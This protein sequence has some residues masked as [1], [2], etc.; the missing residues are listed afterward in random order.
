MKLNVDLKRYIEANIFPQYQKNDK[1]HDLDHINYVIERSLK[2]AKTVADIDINMVYAS[3][4][5]H[6]I[7]HHIDAKNHEKVSADILLGDKGI[8]S[9]FT[10]EQ[11]KIMADAVY[12][13]RASLEYE[14]RT[15]YGKILSSADRNV[16]LMLPLIR[17]YEYRK[18]HNQGDELEKTIEESR[19]HILNKFGKKGYAK[20]KMYF[21][22]PEYDK[23]LNDIANLAEDKEAFRQE[24]IKVNHLENLVIK[25]MINEYAP[26]DEQEENDKKQMIRFINLFDDVLTRENT[27]GHFSSSAFVVNESCDKAL[28]LHHNVYNGYVCPGGHADGEHDLLEV[29]KR[30]VFEETSLNVVPLLNKNIF[31]IQ[32]L[33]IKGHV[34][35]G[36]HVSAHVHFDVIYMFMAKDN[37]MDKIKVLESENSDVKWVDLNKLSSEKL[38]DFI[39][40]VFNKIIRKMEELG[41]E[42]NWSR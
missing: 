10:K 25:N 27:F 14:P 17:T 19:I 1:G 20:E 38:V 37:D 12:D 40:P 26:Y 22:D 6:D 31:A 3:A 8:D 30:E 39:S 18:N 29:A 36:K 34:K 4:S 2:F 16:D 32:V 42:K 41:Y 24:Y 21:E 33:P 15:V 11:I 9:F 35:K 7:G 23:F 5:Y 13:H 28:I